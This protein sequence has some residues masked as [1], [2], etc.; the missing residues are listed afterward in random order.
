MSSH[1]VRQLPSQV[2]PGSTTLFPHDGE[3]V[4]SLVVLQPV[5]QQ[6]S[7]SAQ[8]VICWWLHTTLQVPALPVIVSMVQALVSAH[9]EGQSPSHVS[10]ISTAPFP[11]V[12]EQ[13]LSVLRLHAVPGQHPSPCTH[14]VICW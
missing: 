11:Q 1:D 7:P 9:D 10:P 5:G 8:V 6:P 3:Q 12:A 13:S 2:S 14:A 4:S